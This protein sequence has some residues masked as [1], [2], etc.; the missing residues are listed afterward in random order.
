MLKY[1]AISG[2]THVTHNLYV[3]ETEK[4]MLVVDCGMGFPDLSEKGVDL[5][6]PDYSYVVKNRRKLVGI[7]LSHGHEDHIGAIPFL[8]REIDVPLW[9]TKLVAALIQDKVENYKLRKPVINI[10]NERA[11]D[12]AIGSF[13]I[14]S[15][16]TT[17]SIPETQG[18]AI[19]TPEGRIFHVPEHKIDTHPVDGTAFDEERIKS[20]AQNV[21][22][23]ASDSVR[24]YK[25]G[26]TP[27]E[28]EIEGNLLKI[29]EKAPQ[30]VYFSAISSA[31]GRFKQIMT[32][33]QK[34]HRKVVFVGYSVM[35]K[36]EI[37]RK[38]GYLTYTEND[39]VHPYKTRNYNPKDLLYIVGGVFGQQGSS[40]YRLSFNDHQ[41]AQIQ[42]G[43]TVI[44]CQDPAPPH[45]KEAQDVMVDNF[46]NLG[47]DVR[48]YD[49][50]DGIYVSGH[51]SQGDIVKLFD[52]VKPKYVS[53]VGGTIRYMRKYA[54]L[55]REHGVPKTNI[56]ELKQGESIEFENGSAK[57]GQTVPV[58]KVYVDGMG[59][60]D[61][62]RVIL[63][64]RN[65]LSDSGIVI[66]VIKADGRGRLLDTPQLITR[67][68]VFE[69]KE[70]KL[71]TDTAKE[72]KGKLEKIKNL[73][74]D[75]VQIVT[76]DFLS[77]RF[78]SKTGRQPMIIPIIV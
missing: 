19:D 31:I 63:E 59:V 61:V 24:A 74:P 20:L 41:K 53:P 54:E 32:V 21:L 72:L 26:T 64:E 42:E 38:L 9:S 50:D 25:E 30:A 12:F 46:F 60:G 76:Q 33:A 3:Y 43:D 66:C 5:V 58:R 15:F 14:H 52:L 28:L 23:L 7:L 22:F 1:I 17:H 16:R 40:L 75:S 70:G 27:G 65:T 47:A 11:D 10:F 73:N 77:S 56:F 34:T 67:G 36:C 57:R 51:G 4:E 8:L 48:Y 13:Q 55:A 18:F 6:L 69:K 78:F 2:T 68:F 39:I 45:S 29:V 37:A 44:F 62:G 49:I 71:L 35:K